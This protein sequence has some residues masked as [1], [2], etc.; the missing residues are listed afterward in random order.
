MSSKEK[1]TKAKKDH[2]RFNLNKIV[3]G[4]RE[5]GIN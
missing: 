4:H 1:K 5:L 2:T 3:V